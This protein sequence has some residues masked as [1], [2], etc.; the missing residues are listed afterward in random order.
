MNY[1]RVVIQ[2]LTWAIALA[3]KNSERLTPVVY[4]R[5]KK[6][7]H[8]LRVCMNDSN[9]W[10]PNYGA[11]DGALFFPF[12][13]T[14]FRDYRPQLQALANTL[15]I[16][17]DIDQKYED[18]YWYD[19]KP[20]SQNEEKIIDG[21]YEFKTGGYYVIREK[22]SLSF[23]RCGKHKDRPSQADNLHLDIW[24]KGVNVLTDAG[25]YKYNTDKRTSKYFAGTSSHNT[26]M[27]N[28][29]DQ[30]LKGQRFIWYHW[31]QCVDVKLYEVQ[32]EYRFE[33]TISA[34]HY[35]DKNILHKR[36]VIKQK[37][38]PLWIIKDRVINKPPSIAMKQ[39]WHLPGDHLPVSFK[40][41][42]EKNNNNTVENET[43]Y[44]SNLYGQKE[45]SEVKIFR[46]AHN[47]ILTEF[48]IN[49]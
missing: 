2:L 43:A 14:H 28:G 29:Y 40:S 21:L 18:T 22:N 41:I 45:I 25:S 48:Q 34:F 12:N 5:A 30:M 44:T 7:L 23:I 19:L 49:G 13:D 4:E 16:N 1:H 8:F 6:S 36:E 9:G 42:D 39:L 27:L 32:N 46:S 35:V 17:I 47:T 10:L 26:V 3:E 33:G 38:Q 11:N 20:A 37:G 31:S 24:H 15:N